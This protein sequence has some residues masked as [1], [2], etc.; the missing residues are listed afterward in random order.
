MFTTPWIIYK[1]PYAFLCV[2]VIV[3]YSFIF[4][5]DIDF[6][7]FKYD[8]KFKSK[9]LRWFLYLYNSSK[10]IEMNSGRLVLVHLLYLA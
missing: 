7:S 2:S 10:F 9:H 6:S 3:R 1:L 4:L 8:S 5:S